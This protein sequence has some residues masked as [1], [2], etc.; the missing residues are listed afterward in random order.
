[1]Y[2]CVKWSEWK[3]RVL[4]GWDGHV[5]DMGGDSKSRGRRRGFIIIHIEMDVPCSKQFYATHTFW[6]S[7][8]CL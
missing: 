3:D 1:M 2:V 5:M 6:A 8:F 4:N 7:L